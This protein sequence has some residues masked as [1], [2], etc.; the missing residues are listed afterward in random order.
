MDLNFD[1]SLPE[2]INVPVLHPLLVWP[3][4]PHT[5]SSWKIG[6]RHWRNWHK[7]HFLEKRMIY[8]LHF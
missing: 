7:S 6:T 2:R 4:K 3:L 1:S 8:H 5:G